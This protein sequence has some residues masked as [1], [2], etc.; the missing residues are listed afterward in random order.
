MSETTIDLIY[1]ITGIIGVG[2]III[3]YFLLQA[4]K[5]KSNQ[6]AFPL[7]NLIGG[8]LILI[9]LIRFWNLPSVV[10]EVIWIAISLYGIWKVKT[11]DKGQKIR[12][13]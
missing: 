5:M 9:S 4:E 1:N 2:L 3:T 10:M 7:W 11:R 6:L 8:V 12:R 13:N